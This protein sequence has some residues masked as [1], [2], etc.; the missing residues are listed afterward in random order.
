MGNKIDLE[1]VLEAVARG[2]S[3]AFM[4]VVQGYGL[5]VR[6]YLGSQLFNV[7]DVDDLAQETFIAAFRTLPS[8][9]RGDDFGAWLRGIAR[10]K[11]LMY[12]RNTQ[13]R[14]NALEKFRGE[15]AGIVGEE[16]ES[17]SAGNN[18]EQIAVLLQCIGRLPEK[19]RRI[20]HA[21]LDGIKAPALAES[22]ETTTGAVY[23]LHYRANQLLRECMLKEVDHG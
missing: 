15:I 3:S 14:A 20:V 8:F 19:L 6:S 9:R 13:R 5:M 12:F 18:P 11:A 16:L 2:D 21:G 17:Q 22:L 10:N 23:Q 4:Q 1:A 7:S